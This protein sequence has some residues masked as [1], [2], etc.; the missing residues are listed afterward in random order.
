MGSNSPAPIVGYM[1]NDANASGYTMLA[2]TFLSVSSETGC[3]LADLTVTGY[4]APTWNED[5]EEY[6]GGCS[7]GDFILNFLTSSGTYEARYYWI[8]DGETGPG[9]YASAGGA[10]ISGGASSVAIPVGQGA[11]ILGRGM[12]LQCAGQ[13]NSSDVAKKTSSAGYTAV[14]NSMPI[15]L[16]LGRLTVTGY[17]PATWNEDDEEYEGVCSGG[18]FILNFLTSSGSY[19][20]RYYWIDDGETGPG[21]YASAGGA[22]ISGGATTVEFNAGKGAWVLGRGMYLNIPAPEL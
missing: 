16:T 1:G 15:N 6:E 18:D 5:D 20:A 13:V 9:W 14:G 19:Q 8:D 2:P 4:D 7:G 21:W 12:T 11:W 17:D 22:A 10:A 3:T